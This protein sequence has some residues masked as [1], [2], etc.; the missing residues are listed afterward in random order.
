MTK[1]KIYDCTVHSRVLE[2]Q[3][4]DIILNKIRTSNLQKYLTDVMRTNNKWQIYDNYT[5]YKN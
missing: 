1:E 4:S 2:L 3:T 5:S